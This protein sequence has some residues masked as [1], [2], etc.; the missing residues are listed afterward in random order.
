MRFLIP[1]LTL[2]TSFI[3]HAEPTPPA[4]LTAA[5]LDFATTGEALEG[6]GNEVATLL[7]AHL[8]TSPDLFLVERQE[9]DQLLGEQELSLSGTVD[10]ATA[11]R[12]GTITGAKVLVTGRLFTSGKTH[13]LVAK[14]I[15]TGTTRMFGEV[16]PFGDLGTLDQATATLA[17][18]VADV[19]RRQS[20]AL[21]APPADP[22]ALIE[23]LREAVAN[24]S[25]PTVSVDIA[26]EH[27]GQT[28]IDPAAQTKLQNL[29]AAVGFEVID[30]TTSTAPP[31]V[32][33]SGE[34]FSEFGSRRGAL[35]SSLAR[36]EIK[37]TRNADGALLLA[38][39][40]ADVAVN[41]AENIA[42]K[43]ALENAARKLLP[44]IVPTLVP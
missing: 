18:K 3:A 44:R 40:Q 42:A 26:E 21:A 6:R 29:L 11:A 34:A 2:L 22:A 7:A 20:Q 43:E 13:Y 28:T 17:P 30:P 15:G 12:V 31:D 35:V 23:S 10:P 9:L 5:V 19:I 25:L 4:P 33:I 32:T 1:A 41:L 39:S 37:V 38:D 8:S 24:Q 36:V 14:I 16:V 27:I